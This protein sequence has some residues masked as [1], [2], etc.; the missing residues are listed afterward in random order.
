MQRRRKLEELA[1][2][3]YTLI[4]YEAPHRLLDSL[5][6]IVEILGPRRGC[7]AR[8]LTKIHEEYLRGTLPEILDILKTRTAIH[9]EI[10]LVIEGGEAG[11][12]VLPHPDSIAAHVEEEIKRTGT[13][14]KEALRRVARQRGI[15]RREAY[16]QMVAGKNRPE[17]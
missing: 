17:S 7:L 1:G 10:T 13:S 4:L 2:L 11:T 12:Q 6:D 5:A 9:G 15:T 16:R 3:D 14:S 8:E